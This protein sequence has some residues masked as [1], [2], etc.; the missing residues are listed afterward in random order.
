MILQG[1]TPR[2]AA[3]GFGRNVDGDKIFHGGIPIREIVSMKQI[4]VTGGAGYIGSHTCVELAASGHEIVIVDNF[5]NSHIEC[6]ERINQLTG[7]AI[8]YYNADIRDGAALDRIFARHPIG[9]VIHFAGLKAVGESNAKPLSYYSSNVAGTVTLLESMLKATVKTL[10]FSSSATVYGEPVAVPISEDD[11]LRPIS[12]Y[13]HTKLMIEQVIRDLGRADPEW[14]SVILRYFNPAGAHPS[15]MIGEDPADKPNNLMPLINQVAA[16]VRSHLT[17]F[18]DDYPTSDGTGVRDYIHVV[19]LAQAHVR[20]MDW[21]SA[22]QGIATFNLGTGRG[23]SVLELI[24]TYENVNN[25]KIDY[26]VGPRRTG[27]VASCFAAVE[28]ANKTLGVASQARSGGNVYGRL[29]LAEK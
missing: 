15:G 22:D 3:T 27:D 20:A 12:P 24:S 14:K 2:Q 17:I 28:H 10:V 9:A 7:Q 4:L 23:Y 18:G 1:P 5:C 21:I 26:Q 6:I 25:L 11:P 16:G 19:D 29:A 13:G 8:Q